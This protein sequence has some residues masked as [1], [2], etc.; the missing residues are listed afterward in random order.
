M[1]KPRERLFFGISDMS[2][3]KFAGIN[4]LNVLELLHD[5]RMVHGRAM[6][7]LLWDLFDN[8]WTPGNDLTYTILNT[9]EDQ[10]Y[11]RSYWDED[12]DPEKRYIRKYRI[13]DSGVEYLKTLKSSFIDTL[14][15]MQKVFNISLHYNWNDVLPQ[16]ITVS[17]SADLMSSSN[18]TALNFLT[19]LYKHKRTSSSWL[20]AKE[21]QN[22]LSFEFNGLWKPSDGVLYPL[23]SRFNTKGYLYSRWTESGKKRTVREYIITDKGEAYLSELLSPAS[24]LKNKLLQL[25]KL[26]LKS[27][28]FLSGNKT[29]NVSQVITILD[30]QAG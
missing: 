12:D 24:G 10:G 23:L 26:C 27:R 30:R 18:F 1:H 7:Q 6:Q 5:K 9:Y 17:E 3:W 14:E 21:M 2:A 20:Y 19:L 15:H 16:D 8:T 22:K 28:E 29:A 11:I 4:M 13:T 25:E